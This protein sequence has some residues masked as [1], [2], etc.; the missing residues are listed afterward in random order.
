VLPT[1]AVI[2]DS[3]VHGL[4]GKSLYLHDPDFTIGAHVLRS[5]GTAGS[6]EVRAWMYSLSRSGHVTV[7]L[8]SSTNWAAVRVG[9]G[10]T[11]RF[12]FHSCGPG[13]ELN[14][15][16]TYQ[17]NTWYEIRAV[18]NITTDTYDFYVDGTLLVAQD[19]LCSP[20]ADWSDLRLLG[21]GSY[22]G[23]YYI[24]DVSVATG[25]PVSVTQY[26]WDL[27]AAVDADGDANYTND[28]DLAGKTVN[29][30]FDDSGDFLVT[31][32]VTD[33]VGVKRNDTLVAHI[34]NL[35]PT[36][37]VS[38]SNT[39]S[40]T[41][42][43]SPSIS[44]IDPGSD[45]IELDWRWSDGSTG[46]QIFLNGATPDP[47][48]SLGGISPFPANRV[49]SKTFA[50]PGVYTLTVNASDD[51][52]GSSGDVWTV[53][54][55][56]VPLTAITIGL[57]RYLGGALFVNSSTPVTLSA[58]DRSLRGI[59]ATYYV[60]DGGPAVT[61]S[62]PLTLAIPGTHVIEYWSTD[63]LGGVEM[64]K[65]L[66][67]Y[68]D[69][70]PPVTTVGFQ[71][72]FAIVGPTSWITPATSLWL[73]A[74]DSESG[75]RETLYRYR[76]GAVWS[77]WSSA[78]IPLAPPVGSGPFVLE[79]FSLDNLNQ[80]ESVSSS[81]LAVDGVPPVSVLTAGPPASG[82][83]VT[84]AALI[85][86]GAS[87]AGVGVGPA[88]TR[89]RTW[90]N[91][92]Y[93]P[94]AAYTTPFRLLQGE[95]TYLVEYESQDLL[96]N[97]E[98]TRSVRFDVDDT[99]PAIDYEFRF[100]ALDFEFTVEAS[101]EDAGVGLDS[102]EYRIGGG[103][104]RNYTGPIVVRTRSPISV[105]FRAVDLL[106]NSDV[107]RAPDTAP[108][109]VNWKPGLAMGLTLVLFIAGVVMVRKRPVAK[110]PLTIVAACFAAAEALTGVVSFVWGV[111]LFPPLLG[112]GLLVDVSIAAAGLA[113]LSVLFRRA[114]RA[115]PDAPS[116]GDPREADE[117]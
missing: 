103:E 108:T 99:P 72:P 13:V 77:T 53:D 55:R 114:A 49:L 19:T 63:N 26:S 8:G 88:A 100:S 90:H 62:T 113:V 23:D 107:E 6:L 18:A 40:I 68:V 15:P 52:G 9:L 28:T 7:A 89:Y 101:A 51:D 54:V 116:V 105:E 59:S 27:N 87:D 30:A 84:S 70:D 44:M 37:S 93:S 36:V 115:A 14:T 66:D 81:S 17:A 85:S 102:F 25:L 79:Y 10:P 58:T 75:V 42:G 65:S 71:G 43:A 45:D 56:D 104:W 47:P 67:L 92:S 97:R 4:G 16:E 73:N 110:R 32:T 74:T 94:Y 76:V 12:I 117:P 21:G 64:P 41:V 46:V 33:S 2:S 60:I 35:P 96:G 98:A 11:G 20:V 57:P 86:I 78:P 95:G 91:G 31:L 38:G 111:L 69:V 112:A 5:V 39:V 83:W 80:S 106:G 50:S 29:A 1:Y 3:V 82:G 22:V 24:D 34:A 109:Y 61:Y 48:L